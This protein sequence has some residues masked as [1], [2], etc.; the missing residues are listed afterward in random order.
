MRGTCTALSAILPHSR[1]QMR[2]QKI[3]GLSEL[4][5]L[6]FNLRLFG[7]G[8]SKV[9]RPEAL[10]GKGIEAIK[11]AWFGDLTVANAQM[12]GSPSKGTGA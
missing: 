10:Q 3:E 5:P 7:D 4:A 9:I 8:F 12:K 2:L 6:L 11:K 1:T